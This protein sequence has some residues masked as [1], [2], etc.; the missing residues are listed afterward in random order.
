MCSTVAVV[1]FVIMEKDLFKNSYVAK[2]M[3]GKVVLY[4]VYNYIFNQ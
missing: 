1:L 3:R 2:G 4:T